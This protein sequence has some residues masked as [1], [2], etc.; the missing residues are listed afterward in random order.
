MTTAFCCVWIEKIRPVSLRRAYRYGISDIRRNK[1]TIYNQR[2]CKRIRYNHFTH[3]R[4]VW[5][6]TNEKSRFAY[7][8]LQGSEKVSTT[9]LNPVR[10]YGFTKYR[11]PAKHIEYSENAEYALNSTWG[12]GEIF[13][14]SDPLR[15]NKT[16]CFVQVIVNPKQL[17]YWECHTLE[18]NYE[19][20]YLN[21]NIVSKCL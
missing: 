3:N 10:L 8:I 7:R 9:I 6:R 14:T 1:N 5:W 18:W 2:K 21:I 20:I 11:F 16:T 4:F 17:L 13:V 12:W 19:D 15:Y